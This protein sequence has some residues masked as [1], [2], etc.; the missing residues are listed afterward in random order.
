MYIISLHSNTMYSIV[1]A[2]KHT[3]DT[4]NMF[5]LVILALYI[6]IYS[7]VADI[8]YV[9]PHVVLSPPQ[10]LEWSP[11]PMACVCA[12]FRSL[13]CRR[14][15]SSYDVA[16]RTVMLLRTMVSATKYGSAQ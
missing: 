6:Y 3:S 4:Y 12:L 2:C 11:Y 7:V 16:K 5:V 13:V 8:R 14:L 10:T 9:Y 1:Y 15:H